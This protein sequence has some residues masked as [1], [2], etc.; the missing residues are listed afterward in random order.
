MVIHFGYEKK[1]VI[2][3]LR[4]HF[5]TRPEIRVL[6]VIVNIFAIL[7]AVLFFLK[8]IQPVSFL[9]FSLLWFMLML[10]IWKL[11]PSSI[12]KRAHTFQDNFSMDISEREVVL[13]TER[14]SKAWQWKDFSS[15]VESPYFFHLYFDS[16][17]FFLVPKD[18]FADLSSLQEA[19]N[20]LRNNIKK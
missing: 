17:S 4:Y 5:I 7:S 9:L 20:I 19:R 13:M 12:Y 14:G 1:Q 11:L 3:A 10:V 6:F 2:Q 18:A 15:F 16:R 8:K